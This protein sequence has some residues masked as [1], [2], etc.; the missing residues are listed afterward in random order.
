MS[1]FVIGKSPV[2][3]CAIPG[4]SRGDL[5][6]GALAVADLAGGTAAQALWSV[7]RARVALDACTTITRS[8]TNTPL[9]PWLAIARDNAG[10]VVDFFTEQEVPRCRVHFLVEIGPDASS[11]AVLEAM[12]ATVAQ[13]PLSIAVHAVLSGAG[14]SAFEWLDR[15]TNQLGDRGF[16]ATISGSDFAFGAFWEDALLCHRA[17]VKNFEGSSFELA[18]E[19]LASHYENGLLDHAVPPTR[20]GGFTGVAGSLQAEFPRPPGG[21]LEP[22]W[23][24]FGSDLMYSCVTH[25]AAWRLF[26]LLTRRGLPKEIEDQVVWNTRAVFAFDRRSLVTTVSDGRS[27]A[28]SLIVTGED[29][30]PLHHAVR[31]GKRVM[32]FAT[33]TGRVQAFRALDVE[34]AWISPGKELL[35][36]LGQR[37]ANEALDVG[38]VVLDQLPDDLHDRLAGFQRHG[39]A[40]L[41][42]L[43]DA[44]VLLGAGATL[45]SGTHR[46]VLPTLQS[47]LGLPVDEAAGRSLLVR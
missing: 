34:G 18:R 44:A 28:P 1:G 26:S 23:E 21:P 20:L 40:C 3:L 30:D 45:S 16:I 31:A 2:V 35:H 47:L 9:E 46:D 8:W 13:E 5:S 4:A 29:Q 39:A 43:D 7:D 32:R 38:A 24:W 14:R 42:V 27:G 37:L 22:Q 11:L 25:G 19:A 6:L 36:E 10:T 15:I 41:L 12:L 17:L 33:P